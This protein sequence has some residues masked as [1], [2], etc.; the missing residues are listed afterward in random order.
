[1]PGSSNGYCT[2]SHHL[3]NMRDYLFKRPFIPCAIG[4]ITASILGFYS[5]AALLCFILLIITAT[6]YNLISRNGIGAVLICILIIAVSVNCL[7]TINN[8]A[9]YSKL[10]GE[11][12]ECS[13]VIKSII[14]ESDSFC[15]ADAEILKSDKQ[16]SNTN[17]SVTLHT[18]GIKTGDIMEA[19]LTFST[20][21]KSKYKA[22][23]YSKGTFLSA[24]AKN[25][26]LTKNKDF[27][28]NIVNHLRNYIKSTLFTN[29]DYSESATLC[30][31]IFGD[32]SYFTNE[33]YSLVAKAGV[34]H[35]MVVSG[36]HLTVM[37]S[38]FSYLADK[39]C[40]NRFIRALCMV[41]VVIMLTAL[42]GFTM[43]MLR[44]GITY[45]IMALGLT[46]NRDNTPEN[47]LGAATVIILLFSPFA[48]FSV[49]LQLSLLST[50]GIL[51]VAL[52][53]TKFIVSRKLL[54]SRILISLASA[55]LVTVSA[56]LLTL[57]VTI[58]IFGYISRVTV[59]TNLLIGF[60]V[61]AALW[62]AVIALIINLIS[63]AIAH[64]IFIPCEAVTHYINR[65]IILLGNTKNA[66]VNVDRIH[67]LTTVVL[68]LVIFCL[69]FA[70]KKHINM[71]KLKEKREKILKEG[72]KKLKWQ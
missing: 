31:L 56:T 41:T 49:A 26:A 34:S 53:I 7:L 22:S 71:L 64:I 12:K 14:Y 40:Y 30:A 17:I 62:L 58:Y 4:C 25:E 65:V 68:I 6:V 46:F 47:T 2:F 8:C 70:C 50:F 28:L 42:C 63:P 35:V 15:I 44:A 69:L 67:T 11:T 1:M 48:I 72:G 21:D 54:K 66:V 33:F 52:P 60:A 57:P 24:N 59:I 38:I 16:L 13:F 27:I 29:M 39:Y 5:K 61:T 9:S 19:E 32:K 20:L 45:L 10:S 51:C 43:S 3:C 23:S 18:K 37:V 36:M 55:V